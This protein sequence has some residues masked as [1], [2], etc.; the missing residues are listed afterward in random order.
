[1]AEVCSWKSSSLNKIYKSNSL[2]FNHI[3]A[4][5]DRR[6]SDCFFRL[7]FFLVSFDV[8]ARLWWIFCFF[9]PL[10][11]LFIRSKRSQTWIL[12][13]N[14]F[15]FY[16]E[17]FLWHFTRFE[18]QGIPMPSRTNW[19]N[20]F[21]FFIYLLRNIVL[22]HAWINFSCPHPIDKI[23]I[24]LIYFSISGKYICVGD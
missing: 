21:F 8:K 6:Q 7:C 17:N 24:H 19:T 18:C 12:I 3:Q 11:N 4:S 14:E 15:F 5:I 16:W 1:M 2:T 20:F 13:E 23:P 10:W 22:T 9:F